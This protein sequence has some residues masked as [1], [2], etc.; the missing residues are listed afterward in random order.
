M[1]EAEEVGRLEVG[2]E[3]ATE[4]LFR[5]WFVLVLVDVSKSFRP[6]FESEWR[7]NWERNMKEEKKKEE[8]ELCGWILLF[9]SKYEHTAASGSLLV[10][11]T[12]QLKWGKQFACPAVSFALK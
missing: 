4:E 9:R 12:N 7:T 5:R 3:E 2:W 6:M 11:K 1:D 8:E 10:Y